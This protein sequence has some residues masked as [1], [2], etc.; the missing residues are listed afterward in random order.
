M[1]TEKESK[2]CSVDKLQLDQNGIDEDM[3]QNMDEKEGD[4]R[5]TRNGPRSMKVLVTSHTNDTI[6]D[7]DRVQTKPR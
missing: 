1:N 2:D 6:L 4:D 3:M 7:D 5:V